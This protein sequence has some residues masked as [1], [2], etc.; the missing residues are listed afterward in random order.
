[1]RLRKLCLFAIAIAGTVA[2]SFRA[3]PAEPVATSPTTKP[4]DTEV[5][6]ETLRKLLRLEEVRSARLDAQVGQLEKENAELKL[7]LQ[8]M[9]TLNAKPA[10]PK[11]DPLPKGWV[12]FKFNGETVYMIPL[13]NE[14]KTPSH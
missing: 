9:K 8:M 1:M 13:E 7:Q 14:V 6:S 5:N 2:L 10:L 4:A 3:L 12:P 11:A